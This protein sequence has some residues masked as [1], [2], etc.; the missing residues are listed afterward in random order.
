MALRTVGQALSEGRRTLQGVSETPGMDVQLLLS[1]VLQQSRSW[2]LAHD[3]ALLSPEQ[4]KLYGQQLN[5][6]ADGMPL[7]YVL[8]WWTFYGRRF[9]V[10][11]AV[12]IPRPDTEC[13]IERAL[14]VLAQRRNA[15]VVDAGTGSGC[16]AITL[17]LEV[18]S[19]RVLASDISSEALTVAVENARV[20][21]VEGQVA[22]LRMD[23]L[24]A[25]SGP[26]DLVCAN[27]PYID[28]MT[29]AGLAVLK[30]EPRAALDGGEDG[31]SVI[32]PALEQLDRL[33]SPGGY[34]FFEIEAG[35]GELASRAAAGLLPGW[36]ISVLQDLAGRD[37]ILSV[38]KGA[39]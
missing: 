38:R 21:G 17:A 19:C 37:R 28:R 26:V 24:S 18:P 30:H 11:S 13:L 8:G 4:A 3:D 9:A 5:R 15:L 10:S 14:D 16:I 2:V 39:G 33:I 35:L 25:L 22:F 36:S 1:D 7:A 23:G 27:F 6:L 12:L 29:L 20:H 34:G 32:R 31:L